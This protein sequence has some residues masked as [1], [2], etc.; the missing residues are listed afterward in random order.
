MPREERLIL[1]KVVAWATL[2][3][4]AAIWLSQLQ[5][6][7]L[8]LTVVAPLNYLGMLSWRDLR[9][10]QA[11]RNGEGGRE[12]RNVLI[13]GAGKLGREVAVSL[14]HDPAGG[15]VV[16]PKPVLRRV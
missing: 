10:R 11:A 9:R 3:V 1:A 2:M 12:V 5:I 4:G 8:A 7:I 13:I 16:Q 14:Q 6:S 15:R